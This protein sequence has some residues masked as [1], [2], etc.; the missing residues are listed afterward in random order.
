MLVG[1]HGARMKQGDVVLVWGATGGLGAYAVQLVKNG[2]GIPVGVVG[3]QEKGSALR[4]LGCDVVI[5]RTQLGIGDEA[6]LTPEHTI[7]RGK[8]L[9]KAIRSA[10][11]EDPHIVFDYVGS[12]TFGT[13]VF[14]ARRGGTIVTCGSSSGYQH[15]YDNRY[16]WMNL[17]RIIGSHGGNLQEM[18]EMNR[19]VQQGAIAPALS[20]VYPLTEAAEAVRLVQ[21]NRHLGKVGVLGLAPRAGLGVSDPHFRAALGPDRLTPLRRTDPF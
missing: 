17:K 13:S 15:Q 19:L 2:G 8:R 14:V 6:P 1:D 9:G 10:V 4:A 21:T 18:A 3:S 12:A 5:D 11:G 16:L 7:E 20:Q